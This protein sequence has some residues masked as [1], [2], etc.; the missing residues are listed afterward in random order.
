VVD[1]VAESLPV[2]DGSCDGAVVSLVLCSVPDV[3]GALAELMRVL[4]PGGRLRFF[5]HVRSDRPATYAV[6]RMLDATVW[7][8]LGGGCHCGRDT[9]A[10]L[11][12]GS[13]IFG[14]ATRP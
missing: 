5:E 6:Q 8:F 11:K 13:Q 10:G 14:S 3:P 12:A 4:K 2:A 9:G 1:G 7:P